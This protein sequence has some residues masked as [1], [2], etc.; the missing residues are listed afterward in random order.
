MKITDVFDLHYSDLAQFTRG[1]SV[2]IYR[3]MHLHSAGSSGEL[4]WRELPLGIG[5]SLSEL[6]GYCHYDEAIPCLAGVPFEKNKVLV[7]GS[8]VPWL[9][10]LLAAKGAA[11]VLT[12]E[13]RDIRW[14]PDFPKTRWQSIRYDEFARLAPLK[15]YDALVSYSSIEH[16]GLGRYGDPIDPDGDLL[17]MALCARWLAVEARVFIAVP[18]GPDAILFNRHRVYGRERLTSIARIL[19]KSNIRVI[20]PAP[21]FA[22]EF[23]ADVWSI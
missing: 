20:P 16:S 4:D 14:D 1:F 7:I 5:S 15:K 2:P 22:S 8:S 10:C 3:A 18:V 17:T 12:V 21:A 6:R 13:Y 9:E 19:G 11:E 23:P